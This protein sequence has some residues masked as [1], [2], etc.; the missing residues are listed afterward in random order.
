MKNIIVFYFLLIAFTGVAQN[1]LS[2]S[3]LE[4]IAEPVAIINPSDESLPDFGPKL[5]LIK[6][7]L[8]SP[9]TQL[10]KN[11]QLVD[12]QREQKARSIS[13]A[14]FGKT[15]APIPSVVGGFDGNI[16]QGTP[17]DNDIAISDSGMIVSVVNQNL[18]MYN[19]QG[20]LLKAP[21]LSF[22]S[23]PLGTLNRTYDP[24][25]IYD[26]IADRF[27]A[28]FL[29]GTTSADTRIITAFSKTNDPTKEWNLYVIPGNTFGDSSWSDYPIISLSKDELFITVNRLKDNTGWKDGFM[30]SLIW[31]VEKNK[32]YNA[33]PLIQRQYKDIRLNE[34]A[35][36]SVCP[37]KCGMSL[38]G[39]KM[40]FLSVRPSDL[41]NDTVFLHEI[42]NTIASGGGEFKTSI[43]KTDKAYG[44]QPNALQPNGKKL[45]TND[46]R[47]LSAMMENE[48]IHYV[49]NCIDTINFSPG[50][51]Y[52]RIRNFMY[53]GNTPVIT[54]KIIGYDSLDIGYPSIS[55]VG[56][57]VSDH[58]AMITF[59]HV[60]PKHFPGTS[61]VFV[62]RDGNISA[63]VFVKTGQSN[64][65]LLGDSV[66]R[67]GDYT[68]NQRKYNESGVCWINGSYGKQNGNFTWIAKIKSNDLKLG[69]SEN[70]NQVSNFIISPNPV[71]EVA[72][73]TFELKETFIITFNL[74][75]ASG[76]L[77]GTLMRDKVKAGI[78]EFSFRTDD[79][80][81]GIYYLKLSTHDK[82]IETHKVLVQH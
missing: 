12:M 75:D 14:S 71:A 36:W 63:P 54:G 81:A 27:I 45:Q 59:S 61:V 37:V 72:K 52:G 3:T 31:Q 39:S 60:S 57:G 58:S 73:V 78:N 34:K 17:N 80:K 25:I 46:A 70:K 79:L 43:L 40:Y 29:Q 1:K 55:Y 66:D 15:S 76:K 38:H 20:A 74:F 22:F 41:Q 32:G 68:G 49:A 2:Y 9:L 67:W 35:I 33:Q 4:I 7:A 5:Q 19:Q 62:D 10:Q 24:R 26:P 21:T 18:F 11:K 48:M 64:I 16:T 30:E 50:I 42:T 65:A 8:P 51:Y 53:E 23:K 77:V 69:Q 47:V 56:G 82:N 28:V 6:S 44:L 13:P